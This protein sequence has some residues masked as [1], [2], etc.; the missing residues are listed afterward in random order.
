MKK[1]LVAV[2]AFRYIEVETFKSIYD[3]EIP[4]GYTIEFKSFLGDQI[5]QIRNSIAKFVVNGDYDYLFSVD[6]DIV[7]QS[8]T[9]LKLFSHN[10]DIVSGLYIQRKPG[11]HILE[12]YEHNTYGGVSNISYENVVGRGL[13]EIASCGFGCALIKSEVFKKVQTPY[14]K[15]HSALSHSNTISEDIDFCK[16]ALSAG[17]KIWADTTIHCKHI[18]STEFVIDTSIKPKQQ[19]PTIIE[20]RLRYLSNA[21]LLPLAHTNYLKKLASNG[22]NPE[23]IYDI[24]ACV[25][26]WTNEARLVWPNAKFY[27]FEAMKSCEFLYK[28][29]GIEYSIGLLSDQDNKEIVFYQNEENPGG[30]SYYKEN[31]NINPNADLFFNESHKTPMVSSKLDSVVEKNNFQQPTLLKLD[32]QGA[33]LDVL[34]GATNVLKSV[35][36]IILETQIVEYNKG[37][38]LRDEVIEYM[39]SIGFELVEFFCNNGPDGDYHF[40]KII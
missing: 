30:N 25:L 8:D 24:G 36:D 12:I 16:K 3:L 27:A 10:V 14:F 26:H 34:R 20:N 11:Q 23:V 21:R 9:L 40:T 35:T 17:F 4:A 15:Y 28:E 13:V 6:S 1:I 38:P 18:G 2:P 37:A 5:D 31:S 19:E 7:F 39:T 32:L 22:L 33:E 29:L